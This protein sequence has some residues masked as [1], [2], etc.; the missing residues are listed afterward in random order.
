M[1]TVHSAQYKGPPMPVKHGVCAQQAHW[2]IR[3]R[4]I[5]Y[6]RWTVVTANH[7]PRNYVTILGPAIDR[8]HVVRH[9][10]HH[11]SL[12][13]MSQTPGRKFSMT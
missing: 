8:P 2:G 11:P 7:R 1:L 9:L 3:E 6:Q 12:T 5:L 10:F 4:R 13:W